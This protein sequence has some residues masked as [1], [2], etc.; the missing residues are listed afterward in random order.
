MALASHWLAWDT[1]ALGSARSA[2][3]AVPSRSRYSCCSVA[4]RSASASHPSEASNWAVVD[5]PVIAGSSLA[6]L[7]APTTTIRIAATRCPRR[8]RLCIRIVGNLARLRNPTTE[9]YPALGEVEVAQTSPAAHL[10]QP[11]GLDRLSF[12]I[13]A[14][15]P[16]PIACPGCHAAGVDALGHVDEPVDP[17]EG[18]PAGVVADTGAFAERDRPAG[19]VV[20]LYRVVHVVVDQERVDLKD[21]ADR[22]HIVA[23]DAQRLPQAGHQDRGDRS[24]V[25]GRGLVQQF[26]T[27]VL[28][29]RE[30]GGSHQQVHVEGELLGLPHQQSVRQVLQPE[31][32]T[33]GPGVVL[34]PAGLAGYSQ[35]ERERGRR[36]LAHR[37]QRRLAGAGAGLVLDH[38]DL[39]PAVVAGELVRLGRP[40]HRDRPQLRVGDG[41]GGVEGSV[42]HVMAHVGHQLRVVG[43]Q[44][45]QVVVRTAERQPEVAEIVVDHLEME[46]QEVVRRA[47][48]E[49]ESLEGLAHTVTHDPQVPFVALGVDRTRP[50][51]FAVGLADGRLL[52]R[53]HRDV[54][55]QRPI[56]VHRYHHVLPAQAGQCSPRQAVERPLRVERTGVVSA[57]CIVWHGDYLLCVGPGQKRTRRII[58]RPDTGERVDRTRNPIRA[59]AVPSEH[60]GWGLTI[61]P[62]LLGLLVAPSVAGACLAVAALVLFV[63]RTPLELVLVDRRRHRRLPRTRMAERVAAVESVLLAAVVVVAAVTAHDSRW[64]I[65][66]A[67]AAP[68]VA[69]E[70]AYDIRSRRRRLVPELTGAV[71]IA[72]VA[73]VVVIA[74]DGDPRLAA[75]LW[76]ILAARVTTSI[77]H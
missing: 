11:V 25:L 71:A 23:F 44:L 52:A 12:G 72:A 30:V 66:A 29:D 57:D 60:G 70:L 10:G 58:G 37:L 33:H 32:G 17:V 22:G 31:V 75:G 49:L 3:V 4:H 51:P 14:Q 39:P 69:V 47:D 6:V 56:V 61:E 36:R 26:R 19:D 21:L 34:H 74:G 28:V 27:E 40:V 46:V 54:G 20:H 50:H 15:V 2:A 18:A 65:P 67:V 8:Q 13:D 59:V 62:G 53:R 41:E 35:L 55:H 63:L 7:H 64:W 16:R 9:F 43:G 5:P 68:L 73:A 45:P 48:V 77:P 24:P 76:L 1:A 42:L 38:P